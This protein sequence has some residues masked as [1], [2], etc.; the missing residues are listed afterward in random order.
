L[1]HVVR[2]SDQA[3]AAIP[4]SQKSPGHCWN[5]VIILVMNF[6]LNNESN[7]WQLLSSKDIAFL[8]LLSY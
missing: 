8:K 4:S 2:Q 6:N 1:V 3:L 7:L 5:T